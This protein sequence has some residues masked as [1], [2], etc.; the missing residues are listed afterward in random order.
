MSILKSD[1]YDMLPWNRRIFNTKF[2]EPTIHIELPPDI[3]EKKCIL[4]NI[5]ELD[6]GDKLPCP[7][8][9]GRWIDIGVKHLNKSIGLHTYRIDL[10]NPRTGMVYDRYFS[11]TMQNDSPEK[12]YIYMKRDKEEE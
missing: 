6:T 1:T 7:V 8:L 2:L 12:P 10:L 9:C 3:V 5:Y 11:Y 4:L